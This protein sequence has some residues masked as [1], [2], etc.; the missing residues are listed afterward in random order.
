MTVSRVVELDGHIIDSGMMQS[1][2]SIVMDLGGDFD[3]EEFDIGRQKDEESYARMRVLADDRETLHAIL[4]ELHQ[5]GANP[6]DPTNATL[7]AAPGDQVVPEGFYSTT[8][9][10]TQIRIGGEWV[11]V[12]NIEMDCAVVVE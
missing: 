9:H 2:F 12:E 6:A 11:E 7:A 3:V 5:N 1:A 10:P 4:R 8:N